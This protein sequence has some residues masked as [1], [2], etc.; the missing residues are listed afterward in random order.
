LFIATHR[1]KMKNIY[2][3]SKT[4]LVGLILVPVVG[5]MVLATIPFLLWE[6][7]KKNKIVDN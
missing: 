6:R 7:I 5:A 4:S 2:E 1:S 3:A